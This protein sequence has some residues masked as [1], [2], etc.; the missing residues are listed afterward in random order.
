MTSGRNLRTPL[1][2]IKIMNKANPLVFRPNQSVRIEI[3]S[4]APNGFLTDNRA[5]FSLGEQAAKYLD[6]LYQKKDF[7]YRGR[8]FLAIKTKDKAP[9]YSKFDF[10]ITLNAFIKS[11]AEKTTLKDFRAA[12]ID[13]PI[14]RKEKP[15]NIQTDA[16]YIEVV[17]RNHEYWKSSNWTEKEVAEVERSPEKTVI[18][19]SIENEWYIGALRK[20]RYTEGMKRIIQSR[21]VLLIAFNA[22]LQDD[23]IEKL[24]TD[25]DK[26]YYEKMKQGQLEIAARTILTGLTSEKAFEL[27][28]NE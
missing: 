24:P 14:L 10:E 12:I 2:I 22:F 11:T 19:V 21:Y 4:D 3:Q 18:Y 8:I 1:T 9:L 7:D 23:F 16:P 25:I 17:D 5:Y 6:I 26:Q 28:A 20:S 27:A 13:G 15:T